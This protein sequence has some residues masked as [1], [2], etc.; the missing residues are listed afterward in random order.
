MAN[1]NEFISPEKDAGL[2]LI[3]RLNGLNNQADHHAISGNYD[4]W[5]IVLDRIYVSLSFRGDIDLDKE[6]EETPNKK[7]EFD[8]KLEELYTKHSAEISKWKL[9][10][11]QTMHS[12]KKDVRLSLIRSKWY[13]AL[14]RK[15]IFLKR[16]MN[17]LKLYIRMS[18]GSPGTAT[19]GSFGQKGSK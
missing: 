10:W 17:Q 19:F 8:Y 9:R 11:A 18:E 13:S 12:N 5:N 14:Q 4:D 2:G 16:A 6:Q 3:Y 7:A 15:D 1:Y